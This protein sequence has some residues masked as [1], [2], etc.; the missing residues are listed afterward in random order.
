MKC[1]QLKDWGKVMEPDGRRPRASYRASISP[2]TAT[3]R[4][5]FYNIAAEGLQ[6]VNSCATR[7]FHL[8]N[9]FFQFANSVMEVQPVNQLDCECKN[10]TVMA[11]HTHTSS[12]A[13]P[14]RM[15][16]GARRGGSGSVSSLCWEEGGT[17]FT[18]FII[19]IS[20]LYVTMSF[21][22]FFY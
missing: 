6:H 15:T 19:R 9:I 12:P 13:A 18:R 22:N 5:Y 1:H 20:C 3:P 16:R 17:A 21:S 8:S 2:A 4:I 11:T 10:N 7:N 14:C